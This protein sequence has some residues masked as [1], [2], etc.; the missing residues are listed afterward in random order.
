MKAV[1]FE[2]YGPPEVLRV[3]EV[4]R[5]IPLAD[6]LLVRIVAAGLN[7]SD[8]GTRGTSPFFLRIFTG[9]LLHR[10]P[11]SGR[12]FSGGGQSELWRVGK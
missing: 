7:R 11:F 2:K 12:E 1:L 6:E 4:E 8:C 9:F 3:A 5:P 10:H